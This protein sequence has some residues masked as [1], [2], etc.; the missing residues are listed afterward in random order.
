[1]GDSEA[2]MSQYIPNEKYFS[3]KEFVSESL[4]IFYKSLGRTSSLWR[5][6]DNR[7][8]MFTDALR[9]VY[10]P[11]YINTWS[12]PKQ[13]SNFNHRGFRE[14]GCNVGGEFSQHRFG[15][16]LDMHFGEIGVGDVRRDLINNRVSRGGL[17]YITAIEKD[18]NWLHVDCRNWDVEKNGIFL[19]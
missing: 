10:G 19:F 4:Y 1:M 8:L 5:L 7:T 6:F 12:I 14:M 17:E 18:V 3:I 13:I 11:V 9:E 2:I 16:A 15:R